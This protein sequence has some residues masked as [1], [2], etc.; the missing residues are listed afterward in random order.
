M[1][2]PGSLS[3]CCHLPHPSHAPCHARLHFGAILRTTKLHSC[4]A[5]LQE[6]SHLVT[7]PLLHQCGSR[8]ICPPPTT[9]VEPP[10]RGIEQMRKYEREERVGDSLA[11]HSLLTSSS[12]PLAF[13]SRRQKEGGAA[14]L[15]AGKGDGICCAASGARDLRA[16]VS[17]S[18]I[19]FHP[20]LRV[21]PHL[22]HSDNT[23]ASVWLTGLARLQ[24]LQLTILVSIVPV[25]SADLQQVTFGTPS[26]WGNAPSAGGRRACGPWP[27]A[28]HK[29]P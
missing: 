3:L 7:A 27:C 2:A 29:L 28:P 24:L 11:C 18:P 1:L 6:V 19:P 20:L 17:S 25:A 9:T 23:L 26:L 14:A 5:P 10:L 13:Q 4:N 16:A 12:V 8:G 15:V 22:S 21:A